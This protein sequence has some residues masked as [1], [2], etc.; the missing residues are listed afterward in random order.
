MK[1][2]KGF[3]II[4]FLAFLA[5]TFLHSSNSPPHHHPESKA[6]IQ[7]DDWTAKHQWN[8]EKKQPFDLHLFFLLTSIMPFAAIPL[9]FFQTN[10]R[11]RQSFLI[12]IFYQANYVIKASLF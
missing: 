8:D 12:P 6:I 4:M 5:F 7:L 1:M 3:S 9:Q 11:R 10:F 2:I